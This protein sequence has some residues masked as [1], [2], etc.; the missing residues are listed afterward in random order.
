M[1]KFGYVAASR[2][3]GAL[4]GGVGPEAVGGLSHRDARPNQASPAR[5]LRDFTGTG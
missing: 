2:R 1:G 5:A 3:C 4:A